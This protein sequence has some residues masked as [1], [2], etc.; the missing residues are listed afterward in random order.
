MKLG[1]GFRVASASFSFM[2]E[3]DFSKG[4]VLLNFYLL[5]NIFGVPRLLES[6]V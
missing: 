6:L 3:L 1:L 2:L 5:I 4:K